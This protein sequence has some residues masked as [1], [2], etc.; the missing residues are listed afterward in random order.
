MLN[1]FHIRPDGKIRVSKD[2]G[3]VYVDT[4][5]NFTLDNGGTAAPALPSGVFEEVYTR[6]YR[7]AYLRGNDTVGG[8]PMP[9][10][11][12]ETAISN[13]ATLIANQKA[14]QPGPTPPSG[15]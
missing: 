7:H 4:V 11:F 8:G 14:R 15:L 5:A 10:T 1:E 12:G 3:Q 13:I 2:D 6:N 9:F